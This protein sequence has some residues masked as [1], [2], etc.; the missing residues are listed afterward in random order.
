[1]YGIV[2]SSNCTPETNITHSMFTVLE[3]K[4]KLERKKTVKKKK[5]GTN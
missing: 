2:K 1:M 3:L 4:Y 5:R